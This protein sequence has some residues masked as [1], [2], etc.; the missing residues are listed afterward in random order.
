MSD[1]AAIFMGSKIV[2]DISSDCEPQC[3]R[4]HVES[5]V[6]S[7]L[8]IFPG[9]FSLAILKILRILRRRKFQNVRRNEKSTT[10]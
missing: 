4:K 2:F 3:R 10:V 9:C 8:K 1:A 7:M 5:A 6:A